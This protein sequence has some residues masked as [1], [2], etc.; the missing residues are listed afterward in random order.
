[1]PNCVHSLYRVTEYINILHVFL[2]LGIA[3]GASN[4]FGKRTA[5][6]DEEEEVEL[7]TRGDSEKRN[8]N[9]GKGAKYK[10]GRRW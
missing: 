8:K 1:M 4:I 9:K 7:K 2:N 3:A 6:S 10:E 5:D